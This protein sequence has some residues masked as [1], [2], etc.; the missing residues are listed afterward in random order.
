MYEDEGASYNVRAVR[1]VDS[2]HASAGEDSTL[3]KVESQRVEEGEGR[4]PGAAA[5]VRGSLCLGAVSNLRTPS[6]LAH[7]VQ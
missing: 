3:F 4:L 6:Q 2:K 5:E 7:V 1:I